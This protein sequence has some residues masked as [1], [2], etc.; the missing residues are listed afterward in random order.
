MGG[1]TQWG[2]DGKRNTVSHSQKSL[3]LQ[4]LRDGASITPID[5][6][7]DYGCFRLAAV[8]NTLRD[9]GHNIITKMVTAP[10]DYK[11]GRAKSFASYRL[12]P[13]KEEWSL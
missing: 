12:I 6:L 11:M 4:H 10:A 7:R 2:E 3:I 1:Y 13:S 9:D 8:I 5:A